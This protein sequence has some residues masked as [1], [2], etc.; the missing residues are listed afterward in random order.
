ML[1]ICVLGI[2]ELNWYPRFGDKKNNNNKIENMS[3][4]A[5]VVHTTA[6]Q[7]IS[8]RGREMLFVDAFSRTRKTSAFI[9]MTRHAVSMV[10]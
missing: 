7:I 8:C 6:K 9:T 10:T 4:R 3:S 5:L 2:M 1:L